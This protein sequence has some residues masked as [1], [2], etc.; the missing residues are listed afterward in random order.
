[1]RRAILGAVAAVFLSTAALAQTGEVPPRRPDPAP[2][3]NWRGALAQSG[4]FLGVQHSLRMFQHKTR[5]HLDGPFWHDYVHSLEG[6]S[7]WDDGNPFITNYGGH[8]MM[9]SIT[10]F[11]QIQND[12]RG[13]ALGWDPGN[14]A[15]W[16]SRFKGLGWAAIYSTSYELAPWGEAGIGNVGYDRG[17]MGYVDL[18]V[19]PLAGFG[20][21]LLEDFLDAKLIA[22]LE[23]DK[24]EFV[25]RLLRVL[26]NPSRSI[27]NMMRLHRPSHRDTR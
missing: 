16:Q 7:G 17:T 8:P 9:G 10:G 19:T 25:M 13:I 5:R 14:P 15:Y 18:V 26:F 12:P 27:A 3:F 4:F 23:R 22:P 20:V 1:M 21:M 6:L 24:R 11:I 2:R